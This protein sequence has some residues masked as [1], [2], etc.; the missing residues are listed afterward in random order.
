M[1]KIKIRQGDD[2]FSKILRNIF[3][4][5]RISR[6]IFKQKNVDLWIFFLDAHA[7]LLPV[8]TSKLLSKKIV[9]LLAASIRKSSDSQKN[10]LDKFLIWAEYLNLKLTNG[11]I[12]YS[13]N[14]IKEWELE[15]YASKLYVAHEHILN[16]DEYKIKKNFNKRSNLI[17]YVGRF[18]KEKGIIEFLESMT[19]ILEEKNE[20]K[21]IICGDG[22]LKEDVELYLDAN[23][24]HGKVKLLGWVSHEELPNILNDLKLLV[25]PSYSEGLPNIMLEAMA[26]GT[27]VLATSV[28][29]IPDII[30][31]QEIG[32]LMN[33]NSPDSIAKN[34]LRVIRCSELEH[35]SKN[36][37][38]MVKNNFNYE[39]T[40]QR[41]FNILK[42]FN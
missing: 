39:K 20:L 5:L 9:F 15:M 7:L 13:E 8:L 25:L 29:A 1:G 41:W 2:F 32:F 4:Q 34:V 33:N 38:K 12:V 24:L 21:F 22:D 17:G 3:I 31:S 28:G 26:C 23:N 11:I 40:V 16:F 37:N 42:N 27:P 18:S 10:F 36:A 6:E 35:I 19:L 14:L 30:T